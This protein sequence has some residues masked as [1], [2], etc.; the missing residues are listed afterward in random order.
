VKALAN[1]PLL[2]SVFVTTMLTAPAAW[3]G[4][5]AL[6]DVL[7][8]TVTPVADDPPMLTVAPVRKPVPVMVRL[9]PPLIVPVLGAIEA[10]VG[11]GLDA[12]GG[13]GEDVRPPPQPGND[14]RRTPNSKREPTG[15]YFWG[16]IK[17]SL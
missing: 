5:V 1:D 8:I 3:A 7:L 14:R 17:A 6:I 12:G 11:A 15:K 2:V 4:E 10:T 16:D 13:L 9:V